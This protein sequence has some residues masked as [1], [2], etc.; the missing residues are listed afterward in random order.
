MYRAA[1]WEV[2]NGP[3]G[4]ERTSAFRAVGQRPT[5]PARGRAEDVIASFMTVVRPGLAPQGRS[6]AASRD[7]DK[8]SP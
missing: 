5:A 1:C 7:N 8:P 3:P 2:R 6:R 4:R